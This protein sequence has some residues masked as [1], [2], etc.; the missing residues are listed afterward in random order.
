M[1]QITR[2]AVLAGTGAA[3]GACCLAACGGNA[4]TA[5]T[6]P[7][8]TDA[9]SGAGNPGASGSGASSSGA[10]GSG[11]TLGTVPLT[12]VPVGGAKLEMLGGRAVILTQQVAGQPAVFLNRC[13]HAGCQLAVSGTQ[14]VC[15]CH[16]STFDFSGQV[17]NGP[18]TDPLQEGSL[19]V[20]SGQIVVES[21]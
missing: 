5:G 12:D 4:A 19:R 14:L 6:A 13:T 2:R 7:A 11:A 8:A 18:A 3:V 10:S 1:T 17:V 20:D 9:S 21:V 16:G 15:P